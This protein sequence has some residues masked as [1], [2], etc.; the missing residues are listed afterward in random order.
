MA[1]PAPPSDHPFWKVFQKATEANVWLYRISKGRLGNHLPGHPD[2][3][4][5]LLHHVGAKS[6]KHRVSPVL[7]L[8]DGERWI[9][10]ASKGGTDKHPGWLYNLK[11]HPET[12][13]EVP[14]RLPVAARVVDEAEREQLWA[15]L[16]E[17]YPP[18][19]DY[20]GNTDR[21]IQVISL[22]PRQAERL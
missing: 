19:D 2:A 15:H 21:Q 5:I 20:Q 3:P 1:T 9:I 17:I 8:Q 18:F 13:I 7:G 4:I 22:E 6:G 10:V 14:E 16:T 12:E 11:A